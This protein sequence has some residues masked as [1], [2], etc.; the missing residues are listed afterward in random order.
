MKK[1]SRERKYASR[2]TGTVPKRQ[3]RKKALR[4]ATKALAVLPFCTQF[5]LNKIYMKFRMFGGY[6]TV[7]KKLPVLQ[8]ICYNII[9][10]TEKAIAPT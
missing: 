8:S 5:K 10:C 1:K 4:K 6:G 9:H 7:Y 3:T 2:M